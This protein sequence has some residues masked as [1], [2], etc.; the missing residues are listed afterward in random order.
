[1]TFAEYNTDANFDNNKS[2][3]E[4]LVKLGK[5]EGKTL[6]QIK[7]ALS[8]KWKGSSKIGNI[9]TYYDNA[10]ERYKKGGYNG[11]P[12][13]V[14]AKKGIDEVN[15]VE[16]EKAVLPLKQK[17]P[18]P[19]KEE[20]KEETTVEKPKKNGNTTT[21]KISD[22]DKR[23]ANQQES[24]MDYGEDTENARQEEL[25]ADR[26]DKTSENMRRMGEEF[27]NIDDKLV[28][29]LPTFMLRRYQ[30][31]DFGNIT[32]TSTP[33][34]KQSKTNAQLRLAHFMIN[35]L[36]T[37]LT[38]A[39]NVIKGKPLEESDYE[40]YQNTNLA[41]GLENRWNKY[42][43]ETDAA[44]EMAIQQ[45]GNEEAL[46]NAIANISANNRLASKFNMMNESQKAYTLNVMAKLGN[47]ISNMNDKDF[48]S[49]LVGYVISGDSLSWQELAEILAARYGKDAM[50]KLGE[51]VSN[52]NEN[53]GD[54]IEEQTAGY[55]GS[56]NSNN[57]DGYSVTLSD[58]TTINPGMTLQSSEYKEITKIADDLSTKYRN[59]EI[60]EEQFRAD[61]G[62]LEE[63]MKQHPIAN[64]FGT[65][66]PVDEMVKDN[67][68]LKVNDITTKYNELQNKAKNGKVSTSQYEE[69]YK[70]L[71]EKAKAI[72]LTDKDIKG[73]IPKLSQEK[74]LKYASKAA[75]KK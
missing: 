38:N 29:Q 9:Q 36:G 19:M 20:I 51:K 27:G 14:Q 34:G 65:I 4:E 17:E 74:I 49:T 54:N 37:A 59:G 46:K 35:G 57:T 23:F 63:L 52:A 3:L 5:S 26:W 66:R 44:M 25:S 33:E 71:E 45:G 11:M 58:G 10:P 21:T 69:E 12:T 41:K 28:A 40:K 24:I 30:N 6:D 22:M 55:S 47:E 8:K 48:V 18:E 1:M 31:G 60:T 67:N 56:S 73:L 62:K 53:L 75:N 2:S 50:K 13:S 16:P 72:G 64:K 68:K 39:S 70:E 43:K 61:Y 42:K 32:D 7:N 15:K